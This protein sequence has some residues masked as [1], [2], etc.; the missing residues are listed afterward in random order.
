MKEFQII[1]LS[2]V[3]IILA[4]GLSVWLG[5]IYRKKLYELYNQQ[6]ENYSCCN[7]KKSKLK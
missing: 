2:W 4:V 1:N 6:N 3:M 7:C 5:V